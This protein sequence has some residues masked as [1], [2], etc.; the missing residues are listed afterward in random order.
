[1]L[2]LY[3]ETS[4]MEIYS[5]N[6]HRSDPFSRARWLVLPPPTLTRVTESIA[7]I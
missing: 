2:N 4:G 5:Y 3:V 6:D 7:L 1:M